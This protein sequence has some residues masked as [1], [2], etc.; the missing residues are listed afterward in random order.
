MANP[1][2][3]DAR[4]GEMARLDDRGAVRSTSMTINGA[5]GKTTMLLVLLGATIAG[6][7]YAFAGGRLQ[8]GLLAPLM[9]GGALGGLGLVLVGCFK[10]RTGPVVAPL[11]AVAQ[12][13]LLG[14]LTMIFEMRYPGLAVLAAVCTMGVLLGLLA[15][16]RFGLIRASEGFMRGVAIA[17]AGACLAIAAVWL[18]SLFSDAGKTAMM[19]LYG[20]GPIG[21]GFSVLMIVLASANLVVDF[22]VIERGAKSGQPKF[23]EWVAAMG[24]LVT[25]VWLY[26][27][28]LNL[29]G[30]LRGR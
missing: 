4:W 18:L 26:I 25:L 28:I 8:P 2:L 21:I 23:M 14:G 29:L 7:W 10:P 27:E 13:V 6:M 24:L 17:T 1:M 30:K 12:G 19:T 22:G 16:Y 15:L 9:M 3:N 11:Y 20:S 5:I